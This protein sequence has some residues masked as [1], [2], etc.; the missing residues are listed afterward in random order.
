MANGIWSPDENA[1]W[2]LVGVRGGPQLVQWIMARD[3][4]TALASAA[5]ASRDNHL[6][7][8]RVF[9]PDR[10]EYVDWRRDVRE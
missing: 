2:V 7:P 4:K 8:V 9:R 6:R 5:K 10:S 1:W 3:H